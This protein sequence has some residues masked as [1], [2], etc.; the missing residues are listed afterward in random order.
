LSFRAVL[1][2]A[3]DGTVFGIVDEN[4]EDG[5]QRRLP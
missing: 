3:T 5:R 1:A 4:A 2:Q